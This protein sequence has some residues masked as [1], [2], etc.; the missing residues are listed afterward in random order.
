MRLPTCSEV[1][2]GNILLMQM[3]RVSLRSSLVS[4]SLQEARTEIGILLL[5][6][7]PFCRCDSGQ[8]GAAQRSPQI[9]RGV[10]A[11]GQAIA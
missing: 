2:V 8:G 7:L 11:V 5:T 4:S 6:Y 9:H 3:A 10:S 1:V